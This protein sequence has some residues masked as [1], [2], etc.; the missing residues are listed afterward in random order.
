MEI[1]DFSEDFPIITVRP[2]S[3]HSLYKE[4]L[5]KTQHFQ[6]EKIFFWS[7]KKKYFSELRK[8]FGYS[9]DVKWSD[10]SIYEVSSTLRA[11]W[12]KLAGVVPE[13]I[14]EKSGNSTGPSSFALLSLSC[15]LR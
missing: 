7:A 8:K 15:R 4:I 13:A 9:F 1:L 14:F 10:L 2:Q 5:T 11:L 3:N 12:K 6:H